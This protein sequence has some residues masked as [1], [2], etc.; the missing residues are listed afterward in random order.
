MFTHLCGAE[1]WLRERGKLPVQLKFL[2]EGEEEVG[3][4]G[5]NDFLTKPATA[6]KVKCDIVVISDTSQ[7]GP[8]QPAIT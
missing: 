6:D 7:Y 1:A 2:I 4:K 3:S 8:N 5:L